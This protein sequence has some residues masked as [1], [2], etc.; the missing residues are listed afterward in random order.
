M[1]P[2]LLSIA[3]WL[4]EGFCCSGTPLLVSASNGGSSS[5]SPWA[6]LTHPSQWHCDESNDLMNSTLN[7]TLGDSSMISNPLT[8]LKSFLVYF[9][10]MEQCRKKFEGEYSS[11]KILH[12][13][14][15]TMVEVGMAIQREIN[16]DHL[17]RENSKHDIIDNQ[18]KS[19]WCHQNIFTKSDK[20]IRWSF[21]PPLYFSNYNNM[22]W[23]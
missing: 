19:T 10:W 2:N 15:T 20:T 5:S 12:Q 18:F 7:C 8:S 23:G 6:G 17:N 4:A 3:S 11:D 22:W 1:P 13:A 14:W 9:I 16:K 21:L